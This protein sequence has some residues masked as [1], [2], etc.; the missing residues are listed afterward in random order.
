[1]LV[2]DRTG[3]AGAAAGSGPGRPR[4]PG[5][6]SVGGGRPG[7]APAGQPAGRQPRGRGRHRVPA[8]RPRGDGLGA[9]LGRGHRSADRRAGERH[10]GG[11]AHL[12]AAARRATR[13]R[14]RRP[15]EGLRS[16]L[17]V[18]GGFQVPT[19]LG[20]RSSDVL[21]GLG[22]KPLAPGMEL[23]VGDPRQPLPDTDLA[24]VARP[25]TT[26]AVL[27]GPRRDWFTDDAWQTAAD[28]RVA[29]VE[30]LQPGRRT[31]RAADGSNGRG[32]RSCRPRP[33]CAGPSRCRRPGCR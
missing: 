21:S 22:P 19:T 33:W 28:H 11:L 29:G 8:R 23:P 2:V 15:R 16:Y 31:P 30:R 14:S 27:P 20:S 12:A 4:A 3:R 13:W 1:M 26:L 32:P 10:S 18:R 24:P 17:A 25:R 9:A 6:L 7:G 5:R